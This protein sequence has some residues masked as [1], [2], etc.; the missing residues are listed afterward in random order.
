MV[1]LIG[2]LHPGQFG[3]AG[4]APGRPEIDQDILA[5]ERS[6]TDRLSLD[7][8]G[9]EGLRGPSDLIQPLEVGLHLL[10]KIRA[11]VESREQGRVNLSGDPDLTRRDGRS[12]EGIREAGGELLLLVRIETLDEQAVLCQCVLVAAGLGAGHRQDDLGQCLDRPVGVR[13]EILLA[14]LLG[15]GEPVVLDRLVEEGRVGL[16]P[17]IGPGMFP[18][19]LRQ[20]ADEGAVV[21]GLDL[22]DAGRGRLRAGCRGPCRR[23][24]QER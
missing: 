6:Q 1:G 15:L 10:A 16:V 3:H 9:G 14:Q 23:R 2:G 4:T 11:F 17:V 24:D 22:R 21:P 20:V 19:I 18:E 13:L 5:T 12:R 8:L 7:I